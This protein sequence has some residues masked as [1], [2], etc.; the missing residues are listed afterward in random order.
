L[1]ID[2]VKSDNLFKDTVNSK[3]QNTA[4]FVEKS[5]Q[6]FSGI[7]KSKNPT[8]SKFNGLNAY[9]AEAGVSLLAIASN[10]EIPLSDL[11]EF[12]DLQ[13]DGLLQ[14][15]QWI[16][17]EKKP[18]ESKRDYYITTAYEGI[19]S[20]AQL[21]AVQLKTLIDLNG[22]NP[23]SIVKPNTYIKLRSDAEIPNSNAN[24]KGLKHQVKPKEGLYSI[25]KKYNVSV[26]QIKRLNNLQSEELTIGQEL[27]ISK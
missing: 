22:L 3:Q 26:E 10:F 9:F 13:T 15:N 7:F 24:S 23:M 6:K 5:I 4:S 17:L 18:K 19:H 21:N 27:I 2:V 16:F 8:L 14:E 12:N 1:S 11:L 20:I 25:S